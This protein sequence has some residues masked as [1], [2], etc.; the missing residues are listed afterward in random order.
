[1]G[2]GNQTYLTEF[3]LVGFSH[4]RQ[5]CLL[6]FFT[7][8]FIYILTALGNTLLICTVVIA[9]KLHTPMY[10]FLCNLS[11]IDLCFSTCSVPK[12]LF[13]I[14]SKERK[15]SMV[16]CMAQMNIG[17]FLGTTEVV[18]LAVMAYDRYIAICFPLYYT[19]IMNWKV[20]QNIAVI[21][22]SLAF[23]TSVVPTV[24]KPLIFC[25]ENKLNH[26]ACEIL[27]LM[28]IACGNLKYFRMRSFV[29][30][31]LML[32]TP[33]IFIVVSYCLIISSIQKIKSTG[34]R[35]KAYS[36]CASHLTVIIMFYGTSITMYVGQTK[37]LF[38]IQKYISL[39]YGVFTPALN[40]LIYS[41]RNNEVKEKLIEII[42]K[43]FSMITIKL[44][45]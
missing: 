40:P 19:T 21:M 31:L 17:L 11:F 26:F 12:I 32:M 30:G 5:I 14:L 13:D 36:T 3:I 8:L 23:F 38:P 25:T 28:E 16:S 34:G 37:Y 42:T 4:N 2:P 22:W 7:F 20:C 41:I 24:S 18:L 39:A 15:I 6:L 44:T 27:V 45:R 33:F 10:F 9:P 1:M 29:L 43:S 35:S